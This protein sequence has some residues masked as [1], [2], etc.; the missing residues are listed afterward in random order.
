MAFGE[1]ANNNSIITAKLYTSYSDQSRSVKTGD[2]VDQRAIV[3][4]SNIDAATTESL[5]SLNSQLS[6]TEGWNGIIAFDPDQTAYLLLSNFTSDRQCQLT[7]VNTALGA[8]V[9]AVRT[10]INATGA[11]AAFIAEENHSVA[12][13]VR[14]FIDGTGVEAVQDANDDRII[15]LLNLVKGQNPITVKAGKATEKVTLSTKVLK[16]TLDGDNLKVEDAEAFPQDSADE[17]TLGY[18][19]ITEQYLMNASFEQD[20]TYGKADGNVTLGGVTYN[21]CYVNTVAAVNAKWPNILPVQGWTAANQL[22][23]GSNFC[24]MYSMPYSTTQYCVS[25]SNVGN[26]TARCSRPIS[27][28][29]C[30]DRVLTVLNSWD[31]GSNAIRQS[32]TLP[33]GDYRLLMD[34]RYECPNQTAN[35]GTTISTSGGN[36]CTSLTG[37]NNDYRYPT[38]KNSWQQLCFDFTVTET[39]PTALISLGYRSSASQG[40]ANNTLMYIDNVRLL[41]PDKQSTGIRAMGRKLSAKDIVYDI[42]GRSLAHAPLRKGLYIKD[43]KKI[44]IF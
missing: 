26:Y 30:G 35:S 2:I 11:N 39:Q 8:P 1:R 3:Y 25:P 40:A 24:R 4:Y 19:D 28:P 21:P 29:A 37:V 34:V 44:L 16:V 22:T 33:A 42:Q 17:R 32:V 6:A 23:G 36:T 10:M 38:E 12:N 7:D 15:Y 5:S 27:D 9:F 13:V 31:S 18:K 43:G 14:F 20:E 41:M